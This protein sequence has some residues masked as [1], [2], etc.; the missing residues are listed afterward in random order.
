MASSLQCRKIWLLRALPTPFLPYILLSGTFLKACHSASSF[1]ISDHRMLFS[2]F[3]ELRIQSILESGIWNLEFEFEFE[4]EFY[5]LNS[6]KNENLKIV[7]TF[8]FI[9]F[10]V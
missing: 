6:K 8:A 9:S 7:E 3:C 4:F 5:I 10:D 2:R 1:E